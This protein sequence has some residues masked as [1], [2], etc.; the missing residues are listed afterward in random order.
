MYNSF[1]HVLHVALADDDGGFQKY[2]TNITFC[3]ENKRNNKN[4]LAALL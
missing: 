3:F 4:E 2:N 1:I